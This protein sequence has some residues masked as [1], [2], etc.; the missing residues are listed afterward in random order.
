[1]SVVCKRGKFSIFTTF[2]GHLGFLR[3]M[4]SVNILKTVRD[5]VL[6]SEFL[7]PRVVQECRIQGEKL[8]FSPLLVAILEF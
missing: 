5:R 3:K 7:T 1:M 8:Q 4:K 6:S 2:S